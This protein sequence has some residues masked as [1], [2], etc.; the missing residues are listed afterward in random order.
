MTIENKE[1]FKY[2]GAINSD[3]INKAHNDSMQRIEE[4]GIIVNEAY[5]SQK[6]Y[7]VIENIDR[8]YLELAINNVL[9]QYDN[10]SNK[11]VIRPNEAVAIK[12]TYI[13]SQKQYINKLA[14]KE[15]DKLVLLN[16]D[17]TRYI[18]DDLILEAIS[19]KSYIS[20]KDNDIKNIIKGDNSPWVR[21]ITTSL[22]TTEV[23][24]TLYIYMPYTI[25]AN[26]LV[27]EISFSTFPFNSTEVVEVQYSKTY[28]TKNLLSIEEIKHHR[29][30][31]INDYSI[32][33]YKTLNNICLNFDSINAKLVAITLKQ[34]QS[35]QKDNVKKF[36]LGIKDLKISYKEYNDSN[37]EFFVDF[38][39]PTLEGVSINSIKVIY[40]NDY[41]ENPIISVYELNGEEETLIHQEF[42]QFTTNDKKIR[43]K[44]KY[45]PI[46]KIP[47][48]NK[49]IVFYK[50]I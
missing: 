46:E 29:G 3:E 15:T 28:D 13:N 38:T 37:M 34:T 44:F 12:N 36:Y 7:E 47:N 5:S 8:M 27:N 39:P 19:D 24:T 30:H 41:N 9:S 32:G 33:I 42:T 17:T 23:Y 25:S 50:R 49:I 35:I 18:P 20:I 2:V 4:I 10:T 6:E 31:V 43:F 22:D 48:I 40:N 26:D 11:T 1:V 16:D 21:E 45:S 14:I